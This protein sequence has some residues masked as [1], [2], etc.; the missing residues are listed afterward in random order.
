MAVYEA[1]IENFDQLVDTDTP[2][3]TSTATTAATA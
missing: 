2:W 1:T 3:W